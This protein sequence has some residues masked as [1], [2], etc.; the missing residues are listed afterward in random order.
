MSLINYKNW[1]YSLELGNK[2]CLTCEGIPHGSNCCGA[3][4]AEPGYPDNDI[5][6]SCKEHCEPYECENCEGEYEQY[7][8]PE[9][10]IEL[11]ND[12]ELNKAD[13][14]SDESRGR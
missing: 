13:H 9:E 11:Q 6:S 10:I 5:C 8:E 14:L 7:L 12:I 4:F 2:F 1:D 3:T